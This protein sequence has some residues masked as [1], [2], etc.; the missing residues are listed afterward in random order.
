M[1]AEGTELQFILDSVARL[2]AEVEQA[3]PGA[4]ELAAVVASVV[5]L[6]RRLERVRGVLGPFS[7][8]ASREPSLDEKTATELERALASLLSAAESRQSLG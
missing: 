5:D 7:P 4:P 6:Q 1:T 2:G 8:D 3:Q